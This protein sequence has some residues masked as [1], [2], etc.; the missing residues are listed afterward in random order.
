VPVPRHWHQ[1]FLL[2]GAA[3]GMSV[4]KPVP[5]YVGFSTGIM[6]KINHNKINDNYIFCVIR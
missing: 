3:L 4:G 5:I 1:S 2:I 6:K